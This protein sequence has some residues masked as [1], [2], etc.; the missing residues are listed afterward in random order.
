LSSREGPDEVEPTTAT[1]VADP[2][3]SGASD[4]GT[5]QRRLDEI[6]GDV[7]PDTTRDE[8][9]ARSGDNGRDEELLRDVPPHHG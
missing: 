3:T 6:F 4:T 5:S 7:L 1:P 2:A 9:S 8:N